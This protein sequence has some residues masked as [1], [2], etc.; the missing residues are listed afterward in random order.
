MHVTFSREAFGPDVPASVTIDELRQLVE[1]VRFLAA[2]RAVAVDKDEAAREL[3]PMRRLFMKSVVARRPLAAGTVLARGDLASKK[4]G[5][6]IP[7]ER[8]D[9]LVGRRLARDVTA[10]ALLSEDDLER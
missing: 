6:G 1:G 9:A 3:E 4:P 7:A 2:A 10:D 8:L 5:T